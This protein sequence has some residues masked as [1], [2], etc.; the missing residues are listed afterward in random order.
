MP[1]H[2]IFFVNSTDVAVLPIWPGTFFFFFFFFS[3]HYSIVF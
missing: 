3:K 2:V 1:D